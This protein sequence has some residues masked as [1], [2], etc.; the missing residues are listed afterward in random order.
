[1]EFVVVNLGG[2]VVEDEKNATHV[3]T[4]RKA[5]NIKF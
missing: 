2:E 4:D 3:I 5:E 1:M